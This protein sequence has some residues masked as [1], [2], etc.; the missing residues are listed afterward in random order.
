VEEN[1]VPDAA[2]ITDD[3]KLWSL[4]GW[5]IWVIALIVLLMEE[6]RNRPFIKYNAVL[7]LALAVVLMVVSLIL[8]AITAGIGG[9]VVGIVFLI[10]VI[11]L[12]VKSYQGEWVSVPWLSDF[13]VK[14]G[15]AE[16]L[17]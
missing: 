17:G 5:I 3:D 13:I 14:Q 6:K 9:C 12:G 4:L 16:K 1:M 2:E 7:S 15:W 11:Y 10:Y 8:S